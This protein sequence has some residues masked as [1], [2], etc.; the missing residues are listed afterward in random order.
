MEILQHFDVL[1]DKK[2]EN[3]PGDSQGFFYALAHALHAGWVAEKQ[4]SPKTDFFNQ[5]ISAAKRLEKKEDGLG[6]KEEELTR[7]WET[8]DVPDAE[9]GIVPT[10]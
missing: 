4:K 9:L 6:M 8:S 7:F 1:Q 10:M 3:V 2:M 5:V